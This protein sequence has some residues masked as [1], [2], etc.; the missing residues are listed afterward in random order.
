MKER[1]RLY[2]CW[3]ASA[4]SRR[5]RMGAG[6][7]AVPSSK[8]SAKKSCAFGYKDAFPVRSPQSV[9]GSYR[10]RIADQEPGKKLMVESATLIA[11]LLGDKG[12]QPLEAENLDQAGLSESLVEA[13]ICKHL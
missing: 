5:E 8:N 2:K 4:G 12:F 7:S 6:S 9:A 10:L 11:T 3:C 1:S 13:L